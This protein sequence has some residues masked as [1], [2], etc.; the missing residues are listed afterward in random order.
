MNRIETRHDKTASGYI[1]ESARYKA[2]RCEGCPLHGSCFK[3]RGNRIIEVNHRLNQYK[4]QARERLF[5]EEGIKHRA[6]LCIDRTGSCFR[7][8]E[9]PHGIQKVPACGRR[10]DDNG[11]CLLCHSFLISKRCVRNRE[12]QKRSSL[13]LLNLYLLGYL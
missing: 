4:R 2:Q 8:N 12:R 11:L 9:I 6:R 10:Q 7:T 3:A 1:T 13:H 5:S